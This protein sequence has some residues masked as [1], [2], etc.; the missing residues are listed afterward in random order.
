MSLLL[1]LVLKEEESVHSL[2][3]WLADFTGVLHKASLITAGVC[4]AGVGA[5]FSKSSQ[6][7]SQWQHMLDSLQRNSQ[8]QSVPCAHSTDPHTIYCGRWIFTW[9]VVCCR[10]RV[11]V[12]SLNLEAK[13]DFPSSVH[14]RWWATWMQQTAE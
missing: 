4:V 8:M 10:A 1:Q 3:N 11:H 7:V 6:C 12:Q 5:N 14:S 2:F 9:H 13:G